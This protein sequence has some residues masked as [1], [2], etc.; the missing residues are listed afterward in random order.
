MWGSGSKIDKLGLISAELR[1]ENVSLES[2]DTEFRFADSYGIRSISL[3]SVVDKRDK[4]PFPEKGIY[5]RWSWE[6]GNN[7]IL[8]SNVPFTKI[9]AGLEGYY[10]LTGR[11]NLHP[12]LFAGTADRTLPFSE[13]FFVGGPN[14]MPGIHE[15]EL[16]GRQY[17]HT[18][19]DLRVRFDRRYALRNLLSGALYC[20]SNLG[21][22]QSAHPG[23][24]F[25]S[26]YFRIS[27]IAFTVRAAKIYL[28]K[29]CRRGGQVTFFIW[30]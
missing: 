22:A 8:G 14:S 12:F 11:L 19:T 7:S 25:F 4:L 30:I 21:R 5:N 6:A 1:L 3:N 2:S 13:Y 20:S 27:H 23:R 15:K 10:P 16:F 9:F 17:V 18:G 26:Q 24:R 29:S 28:W